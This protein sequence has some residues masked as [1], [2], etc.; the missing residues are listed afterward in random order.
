MTHP[1]GGPAGNLAEGP[2]LDPEAVVHERTGCV[3]VTYAGDRETVLSAIGRLHLGRGGVS[4]YPSWPQHPELNREFQEKLV[5]KVLVKG[6][7]ALFLP[8]PLRIARVVWHM[9]PF[10]HKGIRC[11]GQRQIKVETAGRPV[12]RDLRMP[13]GLRNRRHRHVPAGDR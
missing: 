5:G 6:A 1:P 4:G 2:A 8:A 12:H 13:P 3:I 7:A 10:L 11:L 9:V